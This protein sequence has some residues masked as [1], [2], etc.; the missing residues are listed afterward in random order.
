MFATLW[1]L[2]QWPRPRSVSR[3]AIKVAPVLRIVTIPLADCQ[4]YL[5][6]LYSPR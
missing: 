1:W 2:I 6:A 3:I 4:K 5:D